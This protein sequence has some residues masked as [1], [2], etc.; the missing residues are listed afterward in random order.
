MAARR[1][2]DLVRIR[3]DRDRGGWRISYWPSGIIGVGKRS[4]ERAADERAAKE[5]AEEIRQALRVAA[6]PVP[7]GDR[8]FGELAADFVQHLRDT[9]T[10]PSTLGTLRSD[11]N[12]HILPEL[13]HVPVKALS[14]QA[15][16]AVV[17]RAV[18]RGLMPSTLN[19]IVRTLHTLSGWAEP[20][21]LI[22]EGCWGSPAHRRSLLKAAKGTL[23]RLHG[24]ATAITVDEVP[25]WADVVRLADELE[26]VWPGR[27]RLFILLLAGSGLRIS[28]MLG[29]QVGDVDLDRMVISVDRQAVREARWPTVGPPKTPSS[30]RDALVWAWLR[31]ELEAAVA[32]ADETDGWLFPPPN[33]QLRWVAVVTRWLQPVREAAEFRWPTH[34]L[35]HHYGS[36]STSPQP[37][38]YGVQLAVVSRSMGH[39]NPSVTL[40]TYTQPTADPAA[41]MAANTQ[42]PLGG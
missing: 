27:G 34:W 18:R 35:R 9:H 38:G 42:E 22:A 6:G 13:A 8:T 29:T 36:V 24:K 23:E 25:A 5:R 4:H 12:A 15:F 39:S 30:V 10:K 40:D 31:P 26:T 41:V 3:E 14:V 1:G 7:R 19:G 28:E 16:S 11:L 37:Y 20:R 33:G 2:S 17:D 21:G 32:G